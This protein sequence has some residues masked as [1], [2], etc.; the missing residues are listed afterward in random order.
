MGWTLTVT[1]LVG[2]YQSH[3][4]LVHKGVRFGHR[5]WCH[6]TVDPKEIL[7]TAE[8]NIDL[9]VLSPIKEV[10]ISCALGRVTV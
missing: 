6:I 7:E 9:N 8:T 2:S 4:R 5:V 3:W 10:G 1:L